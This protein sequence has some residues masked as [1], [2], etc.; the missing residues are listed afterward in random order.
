MFAELDK[1]YTG[2]FVAGQMEGE[3]KEVWTDGSSYT[4]SFSKGMK[5]GEGTMI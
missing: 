3:G 5:H 4:G 1:T 2:D